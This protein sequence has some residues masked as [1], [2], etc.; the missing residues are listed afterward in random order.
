ME[1]ERGRG[2]GWGRGRGRG[3][4][5]DLVHVRS[6]VRP[7]AQQRTLT[8]ALTL[9]AHMSSSTPPPPPAPAPTPALTLTLT[10]TLALT[11]TAHMS[12][13]TSRRRKPDQSSRSG[14]GVRSAKPCSAV[15]GRKKPGEALRAISPHRA[16]RAA[17][18]SAPGDGGLSP[19]EAA[20][21]SLRAA[22]SP[23][24]SPV[25]IPISPNSSLR[26]SSASPPSVAKSN[27]ARRAHLGE[28]PSAAQRC[29]RVAVPRG[30]S[31]APSL[32]MLGSGLGLGL[33]LGL[34]I[35]DRDRDR[36]TVRLAPSSCRLILSLSLALTEQQQACS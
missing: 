8:L 19:G 16:R 23:A 4:G 31:S 6:G 35:R 28:S 18:R 25:E 30:R 21:R 3:E 11:R 29:V 12:N 24:I 22:A 5:S 17:A 10:L 20:W 34:G 1:G 32:L 14:T 36:V 7:P 26:S 33:G 15:R 9:T 2:R 13:N 27:T